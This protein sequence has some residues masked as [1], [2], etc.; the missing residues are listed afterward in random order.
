MTFLQLTWRLTELKIS[1]LK[2]CHILKSEA[3]LVIKTAYWGSLPVT[4]WIIHDQKAL[5][6]YQSQ[7]NSFQTQF[8]LHWVSLFLSR[9][10]FMDTTQ[11][12]FEGWKH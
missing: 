12:T 5:F 3:F 2:Y 1:L 6:P 11:V 4:L 8:N 9:T 7:F 10:Y